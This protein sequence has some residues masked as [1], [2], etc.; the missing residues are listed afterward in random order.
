MARDKGDEKRENKQRVRR[1][2]N[3][4]KR[5]IDIVQVYHV[6]KRASILGL[7]K[8]MTSSFKLTYF[9]TRMF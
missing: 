1:R 7:G 5:Q 4:M 2:R 6:M 8:V 9:I 3:T